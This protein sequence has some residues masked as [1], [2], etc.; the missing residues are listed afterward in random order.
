MA[1]IG[2]TLSAIGDVLFVYSQG[3]LAGN[4]NITGYTDVTVGETPTRYFIRTFR[5]SLDGV[6]YS[7]WDALT[8]ANL[9]N[10]TGTVTTLLF[11]EFRYERAGTDN[12]GL[13]E[14]GGITLNGNIIIQICNNT[15]TLDSIFADLACNDML[16]ASICNNL[17]KKI[18][19]LG[20]LPEFIKRGPGINDTDF[21]SFWNAVSC[22][23]AFVSAFANEFDQILYKRKYLIMDLEQRGAMF[24][25]DTVL[26][27]ELQ[28][29]AKNF[30][31]EIRR[32]GTK[33]TYQKLGTT[34]LDGYVMPMDG[35]WL[36]ILCRNR[37]DEFLVDVVQKE[38]HGWCVGHSSPIYN[39]NYKSKQINKTEENT[40]DFVDLTKYEIQGLGS[41]VN[42]VTDPNGWNCMSIGS[43]GVGTYGLG[44]PWNSPPPLVD[45]ED[46]IIVDKEIDYEITFKVKRELGSMSTLYFG[47]HG[48]NR[49][50]AYR[51]LAFQRID[52]GVISDRFFVDSFDDTT[53][54]QGQW[55]SIRGIIYSAGSPSVSPPFHKTNVIGNNLKFSTTENIELVK[56]FIQFRGASPGEEIRIHDFKMRPLIKGKHILSFRNRRPFVVNPQ[57]VQGDVMVMN[58]LK[59]NNDHYSD[60]DITNKIQENLLPYEQKLIPIYLTKNVSDIQLLVQ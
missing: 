43:D 20:I 48:Y 6:N 13:L 57:F 37:Y 4:V 19:N 21:V 22:F 11:L 41:Y 36:R 47:V 28:E 30:Y 46:L 15:T 54:I 17:L 24:C 55:Y 5:Y 2:N 9:A 10:I 14:F 38:K 59:N 50:G 49:N 33:M 3:A 7:N 60:N 56:P 25:K 40:D 51:P 29:I 18:Y 8:N 35:E 1:V 34:M 42:I 26:M 45:W 53:R 58:W 52:N 23:L 44:Y 32:R 16:T 31:D 39:G 27:T 12:T